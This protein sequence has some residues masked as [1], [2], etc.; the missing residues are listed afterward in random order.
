MI[1]DVY[2][3]S[4]FCQMIGRAIEEGVNAPSWVVAEVGSIRRT[5]AR[6]VYLDLVEQ[7][8]GKVA[9][10]IRGTIWASRAAMLYGFEGATGQ[11]LE[12]GMQVLLLVSPQFHAVFG[13]SL[14]VLEIDPAF[15][16]GAFARE[17]QQTLDRLEAEGL[18]GRN[19]ALALPLVPRRIA[20]VSSPD[21]AGYGDFVRQIDEADVGCRFEHSLFAA[22]VQGKL[23]EKE[24]PAALEAIARRADEFDVIVV[25]RGGGSQTDLRCF[26]AYEVAA[27][28]A[29]APLPVVTGI[30][31]ERDESLADI[32]AHLRVKTPTA[33]AQF[34]IDRVA[35]F[36]GRLLAAEDDVREHAAR[37]LDDAAERLDRAGRILSLAAAG[38]VGQA[39][40]RLARLGDRFRHSVLAELQSRG[41]Q[42]ARLSA[43]ILPS[44]RR[45]LER[46]GERLEQHER[47]TRLLDPRHVLARGYSIARVDG[48]AV[49]DVGRLVRG[50][51]LHTTFYHGSARSR[52]EEIE[53]TNG[54]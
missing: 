46:H 30:G 35:E 34:L 20:I 16:L 1:D 53:G 18:V 48:R 36:V 3:L 29:R 33:A 6:H 22:S 43:L 27:A 40:S 37:V 19:A 23:A 31:H 51:V 50:T 28:I 52:V 7:A 49:R 11:P 2:S 32:V 42:L 14:D 5:P 12:K 38:A 10:S 21:A 54:E 44:A 9:A 8:G 25:L 45:A 15:T 26:D 47:A 13:L 41:A 4:Q 17:K 39:Q 24:I